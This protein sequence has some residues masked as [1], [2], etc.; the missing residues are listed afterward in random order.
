MGFSSF[1][2]PP[3]TTKEVLPFLDGQHVGSVAPYSSVDA[4]IQS[5]E[6]KPPPITMRLSGGAARIRY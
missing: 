5:T 4:S 6:L 1:I 2:C 3:D